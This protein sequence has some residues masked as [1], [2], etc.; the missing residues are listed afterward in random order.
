MK[1]TYNILIK[2][3]VL[4]SFSIFSI[5]NASLRRKL[6]NRNRFS[7]INE[8]R[9]L[10]PEYWKRMSPGRRI[11]TEKDGKRCITKMKRDDGDGYHI[12]K[13]DYEP[14]ESWEKGS[15]DLFFLRMLFPIKRKSNEYRNY[16]KV[17]LN[18]KILLISQKKNPSWEDIVYIIEKVHTWAT[19]DRVETLLKNEFVKKRHTNVSRRLF[20]KL[21]LEGCKKAT[22]ENII[23]SVKEGIDESL[24]T[25]KT[26]A[27][28]PKAQH[29]F[30][31]TS[32]DLVMTSLRT[33]FA[34]K[35]SLL[36]KLGTN[37]KQLEFLDEYKEKLNEVRKYCKEIT[38]NREKEL[39]INDIVKKYDDLVRRK[40][41]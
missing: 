23:R 15:T 38:L 28:N 33:F 7:V 10:D 26:I 35:A 18:P 25:M 5:S 16:S 30:E 31:V 1:N 40:G 29:Y 14:I 9:T 34:T 22:I 20:V 32:Y 3:V 41:D 37:K 2:T 27:K 11:A 39:E 36:A 21:K 12:I 8:K 19:K 24:E 17:I 6:S 4:A 13:G